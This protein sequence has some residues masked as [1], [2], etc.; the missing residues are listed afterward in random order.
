MLRI[1]Y[2]D[3]DIVVAD[4]PAG[5]IVHRAPGRGERVLADELAARYPE[6][7][8]V[9]SPERPGVVHRLD[10]STSG[11]M[12]FARNARSYLALRKMFESHRE[13]VKTYLAVVHGSPEGKRGIIENFIGRRADKKRMRIVS[14]PELGQRALTR[15]QVLG[16]AGPL[17]L[18]EFT[19]ETGR[20]HQIRVHAASLG[21][22]IAGDG[23]YGDRQKDMRLRNRPGRMLLHA[24]RLAFPH[25]ADARPMT[26]TSPPPPEIVYP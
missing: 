15:W 12:V 7:R 20:T 11:V 14:S 25:P 17:S 10:V 2:E 3:R 4:K 5:M 9:G 19:I 6:M 16:R 26:F 23:L 21:C 22:P 8:G 18:V 24:V 1:I 13:V